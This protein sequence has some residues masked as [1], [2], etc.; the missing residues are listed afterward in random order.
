[1]RRI[2]P[3]PGV[4]SEKLGR[5]VIVIKLGAASPW[6]LH[7]LGSDIQVSVGS[8]ACATFGAVDGRAGM[9][10]SN[11]GDGGTTTIAIAASSASQSFGRDSGPRCGV[12]QPASSR[13]ITTETV[14]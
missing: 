10:G 6:L 1:M 7:H 3:P 8:V 5:G 13:T 11:T 12:E 2:R 4:L 9:G 14:L